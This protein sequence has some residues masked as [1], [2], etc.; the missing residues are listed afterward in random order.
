M[1]LLIVLFIIIA[2][3]IKYFSY[4]NI[5]TFANSNN[6]V[7]DPFSSSESYL[8][9]PFG[10]KPPINGTTIKKQN[11]CIHTLKANKLNSYTNN[12]SYTPICKVERIELSN[13]NQMVK[14]I[15]KCKTYTLGIDCKNTAGKNIKV[16]VWLYGLNKG[17]KHIIDKTYQDFRGIVT[18]IPTGNKK[19]IVLTYQPQHILTEYLA[20]KLD[21]NGIY[22]NGRL[23]PQTIDKN[24]EWSN[25]VLKTG[26]SAEPSPYISTIYKSDTKLPPISAEYETCT[27]AMVDR[28][29][30]TQ[31][32]YKIRGNFT[33]PIPNKTTTKYH[34]CKKEFN[35]YL[36]DEYCLK[37]S[38]NTMVSNIHF[39]PVTIK[40]NIIMLSPFVNSGTYN[41]LYYNILKHFLRMDRVIYSDLDTRGNQDYYSNLF[42]FFRYQHN[43][44]KLL[45][46]STITSPHKFN[47]DIT[48]ITLSNKNNCC[49]FGTNS[50]NNN[51]FKNISNI[52]HSEFYKLNNEG[53][54]LF[55][56]GTRDVSASATNLIELKLNL[57]H[58]VSEITANSS[59]FK[60]YIK[61]SITN[62][63]NSI[64]KTKY[65]KLFFSS[66]KSDQSDYILEN[67]H[68]THN[69]II[70]IPVTPTYC[71]N[72]SN[73]TNKEQNQQCKLV[74]TEIDAGINIPESCSCIR[75][76]TDIFN[77]K[78]YKK[79][80]EAEYN[81]NML[82]PG[83]GDCD[84]CSKNLDLSN[85]M[86]N[87]N[88]DDKIYKCL[89]INSESECKKEK[90]C[91]WEHGKKCSGKKSTESF[92]NFNFKEPTKIAD[93]LDICHY[94]EMDNTY[95]KALF[96]GNYPQNRNPN[97]IKTNSCNIY[98]NNDNGLI[99]TFI[100]SGI[101]KHFKERIKHSVIFPL[102]LNTKSTASDSIDISTTINYK[103]GFTFING[104]MVHVLSRLNEHIPVQI[105]LYNNCNSNGV[106][107][108]KY[109]I[110]NLDSNNYW[111][112]FLENKS[113]STNLIW[114]LPPIN[115]KDFTKYEFQY[116]I[117]KSSICKKDNMDGMLIQY[118][119]SMFY[120]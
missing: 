67:I 94:N 44:G 101:T 81:N 3:F 5:E 114:T 83:I 7:P 106:P 120:N 8:G 115:T 11:T 71:N 51:P 89:N 116:N 4:N 36:P 108:A 69:N 90:Y 86:C 34:L 79:E 118:S 52:L 107:D 58:N 112:Y 65:S 6:L 53:M 17:L 45:K 91:H 77:N 95:N 110:R 87:F 84:N 117:E 63:L 55:R 82:L 2:F 50:G 25:L 32:N 75:C 70:K 23:I 54:T 42:L 27:P 109:L 40:F 97:I 9:P 20:I 68:V 98:F 38:S 26:I 22:N 93:Y 119:T 19:R 74:T 1:I 78:Y 18:E 85:K 21:F 92:P 100:D 103:C 24:I 46:E 57:Y 73:K 29:G 88:N 41:I 48:D 59:D 33:Y 61:D 35:T 104:Q 47:Y 14:S 28:Y 15:N 80:E 56:P 16:T 31:H 111:N 12:F 113:T 60:K 66:S 49:I 64:N 96:R 72:S 30:N 99:K 43:T 76:N 105:I 10:P 62:F 13:P 37:N 102:K 39:T